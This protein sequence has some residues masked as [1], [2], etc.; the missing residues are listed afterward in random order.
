[1][2]IKLKNGIW[3]KAHHYSSKWSRCWQYMC[4]YERQRMRVWA[5][6]SCFDNP[7]CKAFLPCASMCL[8]F[9]IAAIKHKL[10][11]QNLKT[12][13]D[14]KSFTK[15]RV[16]FFGYRAPFF[17]YRV[18]FF[19]YQVPFFGYLDPFFGHRVP[20]FGYQVPFFGYPAPYFGCRV[21]FFGYRASFIGCLDPLLWS[22]PTTTYVFRC[23]GR[24]S[25]FM[26]F[27]KVSLKIS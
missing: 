12:N 25:L 23:S 8:C 15:F 5:I 3:C 13:R 1:M 21:P 7:F 27:D 19:G 20:F 17:G 9:H 16:P 2:N 18:P 24:T 10:F 6:L 14:S 4:F 26:I 11:R 22:K